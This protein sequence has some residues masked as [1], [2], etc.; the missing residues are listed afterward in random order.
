MDV[1]INFDPS[2]P[3]MREIYDRVEEMLAP[4]NEYELLKHDTLV[5]QGLQKLAAFCLADYFNLH[6][7]EQDRISYLDDVTAEIFADNTRNILTS[8]RRIKS[9]Y[10][11]V[12][13]LNKDL[14]NR[15]EQAA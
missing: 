8:V 11:A 2:D 13:G 1:A 10:P 3:E 6:D 5:I 4:I 14:F 9:H 7:S 12:Y 15:I